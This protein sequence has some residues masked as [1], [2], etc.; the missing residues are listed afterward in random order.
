MSTKQELYNEGLTLFG[1]QNYT[2]AIEKYKQALEMDTED[3][4]IHL[5][6]S[7]SYDRL[8]EY[9]NAIEYARSAVNYMPREPLAYTNM[10]R[11]FQKMGKIEEAEDAMAISKQ[12]ASGMM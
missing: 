2:E 11:I 4:E 1:Q 5:A 6:I 12:L 9:E 7:M 8:Q 10:S 3:G